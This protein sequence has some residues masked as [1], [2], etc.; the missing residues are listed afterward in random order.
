MMKVGMMTAATR[1]QIIATINSPTP[2][3]LLPPNQQCQCTEG[4]ICRTE[5]K[6]KLTTSVV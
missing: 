3:F 5:I 2:S 6:R 4:Q 1:A